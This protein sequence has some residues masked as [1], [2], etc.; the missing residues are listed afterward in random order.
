MLLHFSPNSFSY[1]GSYFKLGGEGLQN[2]CYSNFFNWNSRCGPSSPH[3]KKWK[4]QIS[5]Y[6]RPNSC[7]PGS[8]LW[9]Q[10]EMA[11]RLCPAVCG[12]EVCC[13]TTCS[14][15]TF[16]RSTWLSDQLEGHALLCLKFTNYK[17]KKGDSPG[18]FAEVPGNLR[19]KR[20]F[21]IFKGNIFVEQWF[22]AVL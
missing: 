9:I 3:Q 4:H 20:R 16:S 22:L 2:L 7:P 8:S 5:A 11:K 14:T 18:K 17:K 10:E 19:K 6:N 15:N 1:G 13:F 21:L 12:S